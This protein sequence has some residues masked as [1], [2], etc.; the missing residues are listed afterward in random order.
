MLLYCYLQANK[1][2]LKKNSY[3]LFRKKTIE[4]P[5]N[6]SLLESFARLA[7]GSWHFGVGEDALPLENGEIN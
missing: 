6:A 3:A 1:L 4:N 5:R 2:D 7:R